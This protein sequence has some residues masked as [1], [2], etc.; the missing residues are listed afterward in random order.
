MAS[1][2]PL[3]PKAGRDAARIG[4]IDK[5]RG[6]FFEVLASKPAQDALSKIELLRQSKRICLM[7][8]ERDYRLC[9]RKMVADHLEVLLGCKFIHLEVEQHG[10]KFSIGRVFHT[11]E[12]AAA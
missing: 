7:C 1:E 6:I 12:G 10:P 4:E 3:D 9:H 8:Y 2:I 11:R 5:F